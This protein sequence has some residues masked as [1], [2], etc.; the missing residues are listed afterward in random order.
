[1]LV[2]IANEENTAIILDRLIRLTEKSTDDKERTSLI[3]KALILI[4]KFSEDR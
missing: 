4:E 1:M 3:G 2:N